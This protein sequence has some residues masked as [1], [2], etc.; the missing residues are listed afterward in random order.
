MFSSELRR[1]S[2]LFVWV[3][4]GPLRFEGIE[5]GTEEHG[6][7]EFRADP[8]HEEGYTLL[9]AESRTSVKV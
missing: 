2:S 5:E 8:L 7:V 9:Y 1:Q 4:D 3:V 6:I